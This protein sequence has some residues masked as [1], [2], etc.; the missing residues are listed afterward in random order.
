MATETVEV[1]HPRDW[2]RES[3]MGEDASLN[4]VASNDVF[5]LALPKLTGGYTA[6][7]FLAANLNMATG[8]TFMVATVDDGKS[9]A[10]LGKVVR[11]GITVKRLVSAGTTFDLDADSST[12][13]A[14]DI[15][16]DATAGEVVV[17]SIALTA[18]DSLAVGEAFAVR[19]R[20]IGDHANDTCQG[21]VI[22]PLVAIKNT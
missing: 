22:M 8:L 18:L 11:I 2:H 6:T 20:R 3:S 14:T 16:N 19:I 4:Q 1:L 13:V 15:T 10:D 21:R 5:G 12:E 9:A 17:T 7:C